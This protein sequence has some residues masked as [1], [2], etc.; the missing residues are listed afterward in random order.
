MIKFIETKITK[1]HQ[2]SSESQEEE[3]KSS[4]NGSMAQ[5]IGHLSYPDGRKYHGQIMGGKMHGYGIQIYADG[6]FYKGL[7]DNNQASGYGIFKFGEK[8]SPTF[9]GNW[10]HGQLHGTVKII[11][12]TEEI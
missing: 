3:S 8:G 7:H 12:E 4:E 1:I 10:L 2:K 5:Y 6:D 9:E 11:K